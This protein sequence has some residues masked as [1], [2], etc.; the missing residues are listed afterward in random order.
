MVRKVRSCELTKENRHFIH[1]LVR[2]PCVARRMIEGRQAKRDEVAELEVRLNIQRAIQGPPVCPCGLTQICFRFYKTRCRKCFIEDQW[3]EELRKCKTC[4]KELPTSE[5]N[6]G[7]QST[8][9]SCV[10][11]YKALRYKVLKAC[12]EEVSPYI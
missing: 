7:N 11:K 1:V 2:K 9:R 4:E 5:F 12:R 6:E 3:T 8:C 10:K